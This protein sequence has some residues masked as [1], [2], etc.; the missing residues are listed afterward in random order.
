MATP[1]YI[2]LLKEMTGFFSILLEV[3]GI[4][5]FIGFAI[6]EDKEDRSNLY[7]GLVLLLVTLITGCFSYAQSSKA[8]QMMAQL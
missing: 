7:T 5:C 1:W 4:L 2:L 3:G 6:Q 8:A